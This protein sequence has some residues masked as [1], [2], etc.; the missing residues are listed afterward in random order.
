MRLIDADELTEKAWRVG[1]RPFRTREDIADLIANAPTVDAVPVKHGRW[2]YRI[3]GDAPI[4]MT[5][6]WYCSSCGKWQT[7][8]RTKFCPECGAKMDEVKDDSNN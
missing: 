2:E 1:F 7:Y 4:F 3:V 6:R 8:G 5:N